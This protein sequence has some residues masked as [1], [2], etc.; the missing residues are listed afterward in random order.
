MSLR[1][2]K[3]ILQVFRPEL[4][5][6][7]GV[8]VVL[9][10]IIALGEF[11]PAYELS[12][13][14][15]CGFFISGSAIILNDYFDLEVDKVNAPHRPLPAGNL[16][17]SEAIGLAVVTMLL[18]LAASF[19]LGVAAFVICCI[20]GLIGFL[21]NWKFKEAGL[22]GNLMVSSNVGITF[23]LGG[24]AAGQPWNGIVWTF[25]LVAFFIDLGEEIAGDAMDIEGDKKRNSQSIAI[26]RGRNFALSIS[27]ALFGLAV[28][29]SLL[30]VL[31]G[32]LGLGY[33]GFVLIIDSVVILFTV[34]LLKSRT[35]EQGR[36]AMRGIYMSALF[37]MLVF[38]LYRLIF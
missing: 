4:P 37:G 36:S 10:S 35:P 3:A 34:R 30:P 7:A 22:A 11:P 2:I 14:F 38:I 12:L 33:L 8:C 23:I 15:F 9:G 17:P 20:F 32:W 24:I 19:A 21:Y 25:G 16:S 1:K 31:F 13:G 28:L 5:I 6:A 29:L 26:K 27:A 18:G